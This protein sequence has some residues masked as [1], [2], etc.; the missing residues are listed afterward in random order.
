MGETHEEMK[1]KR[2]AGEESKYRNRSPAENLKLFREMRDGK[3]KEGQHSLRMKGDMQSGNMN[4][5]DMPIYRILHKSHHKTG[6]KWNIYP[7]Y[8]FAHGQEDSIE[9]ITH[10]I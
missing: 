10:S 9:G 2:R 3:Y 7:L 4:M 5:R 1:T 6:N 8:D